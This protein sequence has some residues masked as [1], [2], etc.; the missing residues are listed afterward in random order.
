MTVVVFSILAALTLAVILEII[1]NRKIRFRTLRIPPVHSSLT[2]WES[3]LRILHISDIHLTS[4]TLYRL[5]PFENLT[6]KKWDFVVVTGDLIEDDSGIEPVCE[7][8]GRLE[9]RYGKY[10]VLGNHDYICY[11]A[12]SIYHWFRIFI[13]TFFELPVPFCNDNDIERLE[14]SLREKG[15]TL[16]RNQLEEVVTENG[17]KFQIIGI[18]DPSTGRDKPTG[19]YSSVNENA[20]RLVLMH[21][22]HRLRAIYP[23]KPEIV[24]CG[25]THGG[26]I[27][28]PL[29][30]PLSTHS[31]ALRR[32]SSGLVYLEGCRVHISPGIGAGRT[33]PF[34][35]LSPPEITEIVFEKSGSA[36]EV[37]A[38]KTGLKLS[39]NP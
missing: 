16:L 32:E 37:S 6:E 21:S 35:I 24:L 29:I 15:F 3:E 2:N 22:P 18:D 20:F 5:K 25:H 26:Q 30:G 17:E 4:S 10:A 27:R 8:L 38:E 28:F 1:R 14:A 23:F 39:R 19:L 36:I 12:K 9:A 34:R 13:N 7:A 33:V 11:S 31:D